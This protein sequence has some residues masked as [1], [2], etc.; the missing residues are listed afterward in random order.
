[1]FLR[2]LIDRLIDHQADRVDS[3]RSKI[4]RKESGRQIYS[5]DLAE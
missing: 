3:T 1:M 4:P 2:C 5:T